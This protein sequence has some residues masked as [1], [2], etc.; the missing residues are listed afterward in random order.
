[1]RAIYVLIILS[2]AIQVSHAQDSFESQEELSK[3]L[4]FYYQNPEP[5]KI[6]GAVR[7]MSKSGMLDNK[8]AYSPIFGFLAGVIKE[9]P[10]KAKIWAQ[11]LNSIKSDHYGVV[12]LGIW[13]AKVAQSKKVVYEI[14]DSNES[15][16]KKFAY[17]RKGEPMEITEIPLEQGV[18][19]LDS[20]WGQFFATGKKYPVARITE[21]LPWVDIKGDTNRL[22]T[23]GA[24]N[25]SVIS[26]AV[27]HD[28]V[29]SILSEMAN[30]TPDNTYL[31]KVI[32][33]ARDERAK[34]SNN[35]VNKDVSR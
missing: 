7:Y 30:E 6:P 26:N 10:N 18:W 13:Y 31:A 32:N 28:R 34:R 12:I 9:N 27:Q 15:L 29:F 23:G 2:L 20:L 3:W 24:A 14:L 21:A 1:M 22:L 16:N 25:W 19:V 33:D 35:Q 5:E 8:N 4:M 11:E 17:L